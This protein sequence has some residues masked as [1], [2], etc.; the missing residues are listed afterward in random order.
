[1]K[2]ILTLT[3]LTLI[4]GTTFAAEVKTNGDVAVDNTS[5]KISLSAEVKTD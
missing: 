3:L 4:A 5:A 1:M 2:K